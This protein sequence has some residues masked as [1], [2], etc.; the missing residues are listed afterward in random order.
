MCDLVYRD[1]VLEKKVLGERAHRRIRE[2][3]EE[4]G[5]LRKRRKRAMAKK[6]IMDIQDMWEPLKHMQVGVRVGSGSGSGSG[7]GPG[8]RMLGC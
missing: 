8:V 6:L 7:S 2:M 5:D 1:I 3:E 4:V